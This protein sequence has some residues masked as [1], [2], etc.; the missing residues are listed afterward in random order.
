MHPWRRLTS[1][2][3]FLSMPE[4]KKQQLGINRKLWFTFIDSMFFISWAL[5]D[6]M[7][8][9]NFGIVLRKNL[10]ADSKSSFRTMA[11]NR[12][13]TFC[14][15]LCIQQ[16]PREAIA[17]LD[18]S[19]RIGAALWPVNPTANSINSSDGWQ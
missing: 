15:P 4:R 17:I 10:K 5:S 9:N 12:M 2:R 13:P 19:A 7:S 16:P 1:W 6:F 11:N 8:V 18:Q 3:Q 14:Q